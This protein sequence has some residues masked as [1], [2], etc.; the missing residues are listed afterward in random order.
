MLDAPARRWLKETIARMNPDHEW[1]GSSDL[2]GTFADDPGNGRAIGDPGRALR[3][4]PSGDPEGGFVVGQEIPAVDGLVVGGPV[5]DEVQLVQVVL[6]H[7][8]AFG[9]SLG[10]TGKGFT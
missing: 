3:R 1:P 5:A 10:A 7:A 4:D 2:A 9:Q 6:D 8:A